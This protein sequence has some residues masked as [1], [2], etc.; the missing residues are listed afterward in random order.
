MKGDTYAENVA[1]NHVWPWRAG[2]GQAHVH[3]WKEK[4]MCI[5][6]MYK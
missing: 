1:H 6:D 3:S 4:K 2:Q 5:K